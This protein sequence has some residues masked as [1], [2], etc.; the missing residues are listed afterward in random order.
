[1]GHQIF[2]TSPITKPH[3]TPN[4]TTALA[5]KRRW[6]TSSHILPPSL[7]RWYFRLAVESH[8]IPQEI[9]RRVCWRCTTRIVGKHTVVINRPLHYDRGRKA[10][11]TFKL[12]ERRLRQTEGSNWAFLG[13]RI[14]LATSWRQPDKE[15]SFRFVDFGLYSSFLRPVYGLL[16]VS[17]AFTGGSW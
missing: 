6:N 9:S 8:T 16:S 5:P 13:V 17:M 7:R 15:I 11:S 14:L 3:Q 1:M 12:Q 10:L 2:G 4:W